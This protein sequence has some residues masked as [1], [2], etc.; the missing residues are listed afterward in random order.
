MPNVLWELQG[1]QRAV[2]APAKPGEEAKVEKLELASPGKLSPAQFDE[3]AR[4]ITAFLDYAGEP[5]KLK[6]EAMG[7]WVVLYLALFTF[8]AWLLKHVFWKDVH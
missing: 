5:A 3:A 4:D 7:A 1:S 6:R 2:M 8:L